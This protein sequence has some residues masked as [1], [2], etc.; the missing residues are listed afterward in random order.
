MKY[1]VTAYSIE[2][3]TKR[4]QTLANETGESI[5]LFQFV[6]EL[7]Q[8]VKTGFSYAFTLPI[9]GEEIRRIYPYV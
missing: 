8:M 7:E 6:L 9:Y 5:V 3:A 2:E 4:A 1:P